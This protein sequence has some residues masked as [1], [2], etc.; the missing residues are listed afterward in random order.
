MVDPTKETWNK[1]RSMNI[2]H[3]FILGPINAESLLKDPKHLAFSLSRYKFAAKMLKNCRHIIE[4]GCGEGIGIFTLLAETK[5]RITAIDFDETQIKYA[6]LNVLPQAEGRAIFICQNIVSRPYQGKKGNGLVCVDVI[7][8]IHRSEERGF[9]MHC[10]SCLDNGGVAV[11][12]TPNQYADKYASKRSKKGHINL[13]T[14]ERLTLT[15]EKY[16]RHIFLFSMN[17]EIVHT[18][19]YKMA[20][21]LMA[22]CVK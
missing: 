14:P 3:N 1:V 10:S 15:L 11:F 12:G 22:L 21:Y 7:E 13:F 8:H 6:K 4:V 9:F 2:S 20:H 19:F 18:G 5:A 17:D 16:F